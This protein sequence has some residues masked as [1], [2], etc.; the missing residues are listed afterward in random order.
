MYGQKEIYFGE[1]VVVKTFMI[2]ISNKCCSFELYL[3]KKNRFKYRFLEIC[4]HK[5]Y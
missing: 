3:S 2:P 4:F 5:K 1:K